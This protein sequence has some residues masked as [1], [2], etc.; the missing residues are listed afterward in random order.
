M[1]E[2]VSDIE[3]FWTAKN[4]GFLYQNEISSIVYDFRRDWSWPALPYGLAKPVISTSI[5]DVFTVP[6]C[7]QRN[8]WP[9]EGSDWDLTQLSS[10][11][12]GTSIKSFRFQS[13]CNFFKFFK[14]FEF[15]DFFNFFSFSICPTFQF[16]QSIL[17]NFF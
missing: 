11:T 9:F 10:Q 1:S 12:R 6:K 13:V 8:I 5:S 2:W 4:A 15:F 7:L 14:F 3:L 17:F 16:C